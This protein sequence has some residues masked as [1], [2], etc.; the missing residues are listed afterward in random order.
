MA[1]SVQ[2]LNAQ[3]DGA[4]ALRGSFNFRDSD[5]RVNARGQFVRMNQAGEPVMVVNSL[6]T[7]DEWVEFEDMVL[8]ASRH[9]LRVVDRFR[10]AGLV[11]PL[12][13][14]GSLEARWY[15]QSEITAASVN[16]TGRGRAERDLP[17]VLPDGVPVPVIFKEFSIDW[18]TLEASRRLGDGLDMTTMVEATRVVAEGYENLVVNGN[19]NVRLNNRPIYGLR[20]HPKRRT[21]TAGNFGGGDWGTIANVTNTVAGMIS[22]ANGQ[23]NAGPFTLYVSQAQYNQAALAYYTDGSGQSPLLRLQQMAMIEAVEPLPA[24]TLPDGELLL[25]Q[26]GPEYMELAEAM[27]LQVREWTNGDGTETMFKVMVIGTPKIK[28]RYGNQTGIVHAT[29]A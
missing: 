1:D 5:I 27:S 13:S 24:K 20:T 6:L 22:A 8:T 10:S 16:M 7:E 2:I 28:A 11:R 15:V 12:G 29:G 18:R 25:L 21:D 9:P 23:D 26:M 17:E 4:K 3:T 14:V 19:T